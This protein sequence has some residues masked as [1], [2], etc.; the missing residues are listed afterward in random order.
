MPKEPPSENSLDPRDPDY[1][2]P[3][4]F[5]T[6]N[7]YRCRDGEKPCVQGGPH[8]CEFPHARDD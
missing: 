5:A 8:R 3:G 6:H 7:C 1:S 4:V 2:R